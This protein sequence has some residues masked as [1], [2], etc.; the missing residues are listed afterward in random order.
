MS[1]DAVLLTGGRAT[2]MGER[3]KPARTV[4]GHPLVLRTAEAVRG[5]ERLI[6]VGPDYPGL[7]AAVVTREDPPSG[8]PAAAIGAG[9]VHVQAPVV[10][11]LAAD[12]PFL[13]EAVVRELVASVESCAVALLVD[14]RGR[15][16][17]LVAAWQVAALR[18]AL[19]GSTGGSVRSVLARTTPVR[20][21]DVT[22]TVGD[23]PPPWFDC[24]T[25]A[26]L[27]RAEELWR[28]RARRV[29]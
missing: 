14:D 26:D 12:L 18:Q 19:A 29:D 5:A 13:T 1:Y 7:R 4:G 24:D 28:E 6:V 25:E 23:G 2:R 11:T 22:A 10:V 27:D 3:D 15:D 8:G 9:L 20:R 17:Y 21:L 16:Q